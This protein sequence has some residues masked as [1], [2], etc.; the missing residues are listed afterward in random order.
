MRKLTYEKVYDTLKRRIEEGI[1]KPG[2]QIPTIEQLSIELGVGL[3]SVREAIR[4]LSKQKIVSTEQGRGT[5]IMQDLPTNN[6]DVHL[7][8]LE[9][10]TWKQLTE[11]RLMI[12]PELSALAAE[13]GTEE[14]IQALLLNVDGMRTKV[15]RGDDFLEEDLAFHALIAKAAGNEVMLNML[16]LINDLLLDSRRITMRMPRMN[17]RAVSYHELISHAVKQRNANQA[18]ELMRMHIQDMMDESKFI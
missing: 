7:K 9:R 11:A 17:E 3:S 16:E 13:H 2:E 5:F 6:V 4:I 8:F 12:E 10:A 15:R 18:R 1:W 14:V